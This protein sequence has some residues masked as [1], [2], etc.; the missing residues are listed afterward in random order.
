MPFQSPGAAAGGLAAPLVTSE[1]CPLGW[2]PALAAGVPQLVV[3][4]A[5]DQFDNGQRLQKLGCGLSLPAL[6]DL[7]AAEATL[8]RL[9]EDGAIGTA[10]ARLQARMEPAAKAT[11]RAADVVVGLQQEARSAAWESA[12]LAM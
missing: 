5:Y 9:L 7:D 11:A 10:C 4:Y 12:S 3:P 6:T 1:G 8:R 2:N